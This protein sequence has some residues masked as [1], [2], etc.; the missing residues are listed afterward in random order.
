MHQNMLVCWLVL[1]TLV[2]QV[3]AVS[4]EHWS[5]GKKGMKTHMGLWEKCVDKSCVHTPVDGDTAF[6]KNSLYAVRALAV[7][8]AVLVLFSLV[9]STV[10]TSYKRCQLWCLVGGGV[11]S[12]VACVVWSAKMMKMNG[13]MMKSCS[14]KRMNYMIR[15][16][17]KPERKASADPAASSGNNAASVSV[18]S[19]W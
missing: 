17:K 19:S 4:T 5:K 2:L 11:L 15:S 6:P 8:G 1:V 16:F 12:L 14:M 9:C 7:A 18:R 13:R 10:S 3:L